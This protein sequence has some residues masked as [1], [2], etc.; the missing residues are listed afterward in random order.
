MKIY[1][2]LNH[3]NSDSKTFVTIG[4]FDG[5]HIGHQKV[6][7]KLVNSAKK[8]N[9]SSVLLTFFPHPRMVL[10]KDID[11]KLINTID[12]RIQLLE[13][14]GLEN[15][16][17][18]PFTK[19]FS[20][21]TA[22]DFVRSIL[23]NTLNISRLIIGYDHHFGKNREGTFEQ[24]EEYGYTY[25]FKVK[26]ISQ[27][28]ISDIAVSS[29]KIRNAIENCEIEKANKY[30]GY[31]FMLTGDVVKG[32]NLGEKIGFPT[33]NLFIEETYKLIPKTGAYVVKSKIADKT[34][35]GMMNI[36][37]RPTVSGKNQTIE[38]HFFDFNENLYGERIQV[39]VLS[40]LRDEQKFDS[41]EALKNQLSMDREKS[42]NFINGTFF[43]G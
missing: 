34:I 38:I 19:K 33:A 2:N 23:V 11:I 17:I 22:L 5:V 26:K 37:Y 1:S 39:E 42:L 28:D 13:K 6:I 18:Q 7:K 16:V 27:Q 31:F 8:K 29:T 15:L 4:T 32:K 25:D 9:A 35:F 20:K 21:Q 30:L 40:F 3:Y 14:T 24:L 43:E 36:G 10:Q 12:E 41:V